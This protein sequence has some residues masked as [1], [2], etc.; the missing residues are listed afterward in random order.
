MKFKAPRDV[1]ALAKT[2]A[3]SSV[4]FSAARAAGEQLA[5]GFLAVLLARAPFTAGLYPFGLAL[6]VGASDR[7]AIAALVGFVLSHWTGAAVGSTAYVAAAGVVAALRWILAG[8]SRGRYKKS[9]FLPCLVTAL[10]TAALVELAVLALSGSFS[11]QGVLVSLSGLTLMGAFSYFYSVSFDSLHRR[12]AILE[13]SSV[14][15][16]C[17]TLAL[18]SVLMALMPVSV[19]P[20]SLGRVL[21]FAGALFAA[22]LL[23]SP[24]DIMAYGG[25][26]CA[27]VLAEPEFA[28]AAAGLCIAGALASLFKK[29]GRAVLCLVFV[30]AATLLCTAAPSYIFAVTYMSEVFFGALIFLVLPIKSPADTKSDF[31][32]DSLAGTSASLSLRLE[33][34][35]N[36]L[37]DITA[38]LDKTVELKS[39]R[40]D[41][42][43]LYSHVAE[44]VCRKCALMSYCWV[45]HYDDTSQTFVKLTPALQSGGRVSDENF[46]ELFRSRCMNVSAVR[47]EVNRGYGRFL[48]Y[49][50]RVENTQLYKSMLKKQFI[51]V[52]DMLESAKGE[53]CSFKQWDEHRS[54]RVYDCAARLQL[55]VENA[56][57]VYDSSNRPHITVTLADS[58]PDPLLR[59]LT[60]G[61][62]MIAGRTLSP[63]S[64]ESRNGSMLL[65]YSE[66]PAFAVQT[67]VAQV[68]ADSRVC[69]DV[70]SLCTDLAG[71][72]HVIMSDG[73]GTGETAARDGAVCC[74]FL[75]RLLESSFPI[76]RA[77]ELA[78]S[79]LAL[80]ED[81]ETACT[82]DVMSFNVFSGELRLFKAG[83]APTF[84]L[85]GNH[86]TRIDGRTLPVGILER[87]VSSES[88]L[89]LSEGD[90]VVM[91]SDGA[92]NSD[93]PYIEQTLKLMFRNSPQ[94]ICDELVRRAQNNRNASD[95]IT[96]VVAKI[97]RCTSKI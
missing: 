17:M 75:T 94:E 42:D 82:L 8:I 18:S 92:V 47:A 26:A 64:I 56:G 90:V 45:K 70:Y 78:N 88:N 54:R 27:V 44:S 9:F 66:Q 97:S 16:A 68:S 83:A 11:G 49:M 69:G 33:C 23:N 30:L 37:R 55:P 80:R 86:V 57:F 31:V 10:S 96:I 43:K 48:D 63:P 29:R 41:T 89:A 53:L 50:R 24:F 12:R 6:V 4:I 85:T 74:A 19:G 93:S 62:S 3:N 91:A 67:A 38:L 58:P 76:K 61:L 95:D 59:R 32:N 81:S 34:M 22:S 77:A 1:I 25:T 73:M 39:T 71:N 2:R 35:S 84:C 65:S 60:M 15:K 40:C 20:F 46:D 7:F 21:C 5:V 28:F 51:A 52:C 14:Q 72:V 13:Y 36:S 87:V 79:A